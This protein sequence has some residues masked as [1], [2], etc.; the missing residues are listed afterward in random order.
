MLG[1]DIELMI[2]QDIIPAHKST[3]YSLFFTHLLL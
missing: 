1:D 2:C 3:N